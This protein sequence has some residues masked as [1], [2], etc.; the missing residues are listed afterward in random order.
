MAT[1]VFDQDGLGYP[2]FIEW[3]E[4]RSPG[5]PRDRFTF[6]AEPTFARPLSQ[7]L[8][9]AGFKPS[10]IKWV[11]TPEV[12]PYRK[13][14]GIGKA[15]KN[16]LDD[17]RAMAM[18][19]FEAATS[20]FA[21]RTFLPGVRES[22]RAEGI[23]RLVANYWRLSDDSIRIQNQVWDLVLRLFPECWRVWSRGETIQKP[24]GSHFELRKMALF[25]SPV[26]MEVLSAFPGARA[27]AEAGFEKV[28]ATVGRRGMR[29]ELLRKIVALAEQSAGVDDPLDAERLRLLIDEY[30]SIR[31]RLG[32][33]LQTVEGVIA[34]DAVLASLRTI[35]CLGPQLL[36]VIVGALGDVTRFPDV[37]AVKKYL[38][39]APVPM[40]Q[41][42]T[43]DPDCRPVQIWRLPANKYER[44]GGQKRLAYKIRG[45]QDAR[46][47]LYW[48]FLLLVRSSVRR[49]DD[50]FVRLYQRLKA[51][52]QGQNRWF[53]KARWKVAAKLVTV[54]FHCLRYREVYDPAKLLGDL[55]TA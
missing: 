53:G 39:I 31:S 21:G 54:I 43:M 27:I 41:T 23:G 51:E 7:Y 13:A 22:A 4:N 26:P 47:A 30:Q 17:A 8:V 45:R 29:R 14:K 38:N 32:A 35:P 52:H 42:G 15:G 28:W 16:D 2:R 11:R 10:E 46:R 48:W 18:M 36:G 37:D 24:D 6:V 19:A 12:G 44:Q 49:P 25:G 20:P 55:K 9:K 34:A 3:L 40:P 50:P 1:A 33:Y 5:V